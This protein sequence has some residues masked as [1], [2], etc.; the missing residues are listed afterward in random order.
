MPGLIGVS[1]KYPWDRVCLSGLDGF[2]RCIDGESG[3][4]P[5]AGKGCG[6]DTCG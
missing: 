2:D 1:P 6:R 4:T 5:G 3:V